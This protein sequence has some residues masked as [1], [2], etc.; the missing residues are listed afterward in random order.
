[1]DTETTSMGIEKIKQALK[2]ISYYF[3]IFIIIY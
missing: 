3:T 1:M 2:L